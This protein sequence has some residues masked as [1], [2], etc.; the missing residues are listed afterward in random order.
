MTKRNNLNPKNQGNRELTRA[1]KA[2]RKRRSQMITK[3]ENAAKVIFV[4]LLIVLLIY[5]ISRLVDKASQDQNPTGTTQPTISET[6]NGTESTTTPSVETT[7]PTTEPEDTTSPEEENVPRFITKDLNSDVDKLD[8][9][10][11][12]RPKAFTTPKMNRVITT[13]MK[14]AKDANCDLAFSFE[15]NIMYVNYHE[16]SESYSATFDFYDGKEDKGEELMD[17]S[18]FKSADGNV[19]VYG[20][21]HDGKW[22]EKVTLD[23]E[24]S[25]REV[26][27]YDVNLPLFMLNESKTSIRIPGDYSLFL[28]GDNMLA[29]YKDGQEVTIEV[30]EE[31]SKIKEINLEY[32]YFIT[33]K[34]QV[35]TIAITKA[36]TGEPIVSYE[37]AGFIKESGVFEDYMEE[38]TDDEKKIL[39]PIF[40]D[41]DG[42]R[43]VLVPYNW[44]LY[45]AQAS[46][47][48]EEVVS[49]DK[50]YKSHLI[51][52]SMAQN[53]P[54]EVTFGCNYTFYDKV[55]F[56]DGLIIKEWIGPVESN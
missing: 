12:N 44:D 35:Y 34:G 54:V 2:A 47:Y 27:S 5:G 49:L 4:L 3:I 18:I 20:F 43:Q 45:K 26:L 39:L 15:G 10:K 52:L 51:D 41:G 21:T 46:G 30:F 23:G 11:E 40:R 13:A 56:E 33:E 19:V 9:E 50:I 38:V 55:F 24:N 31:A 25:K 17:C 6:T 29:I 16:D 7:V 53:E 32:A 1:E 8:A 48:L 37:F 36:L 28:L 14:E 22:F 42:K